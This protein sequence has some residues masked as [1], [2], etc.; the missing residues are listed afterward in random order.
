L[1]GEL[2]EARSCFLGVASFALAVR[3]SSAR[4]VALDEGGRPRLSIWLSWFTAIFV[5]NPGMPWWKEAA[6]SMFAD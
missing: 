2:A 5:F 3:R 6:A 1:I 4:P